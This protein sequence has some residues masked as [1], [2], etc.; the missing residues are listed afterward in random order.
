LKDK[1]EGVISIKLSN[2]QP[3]GNVPQEYRGVKNKKQKLINKQILALL[4]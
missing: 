4:N 1:E 3:G 2:D